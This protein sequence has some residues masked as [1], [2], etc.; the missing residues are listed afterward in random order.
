MVAV[1]LAVSHASGRPS[2]SLS[3]GTV[4]LKVRF[5]GEATFLARLRTMTR[6]VAALVGCA[7]VRVK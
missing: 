7:W 1:G 6:Q 4:R 5:S 3:A 2:P